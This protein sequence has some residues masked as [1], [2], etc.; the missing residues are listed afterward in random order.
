MLAHYY[1][2]MLMLMTMLYLYAPFAVYAMLDDI[3]R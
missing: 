3:K 2:D 1:A